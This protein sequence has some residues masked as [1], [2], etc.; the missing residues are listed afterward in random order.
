[1]S[2][3]SLEGGAGDD[4][5]TDDT[6]DTNVSCNK[7]VFPVNTKIFLIIHTYGNIAFNVA[8]GDFNP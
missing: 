7:A 3:H 2:I 5:D 6:D 1:M 8:N 4:R